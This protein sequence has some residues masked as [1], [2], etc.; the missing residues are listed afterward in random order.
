MLTVARKRLRHHLGAFLV[1]TVTAIVSLVVLGVLQLLGGIVTD[2]A[3]RTTVQAGDRAGR[4]IAVGGS[5]P[6][7][8][9]DAARA[10]IAEAAANQPGA[11]T[12]EVLEAVSRGISGRAGADRARL[13]VVADLPRWADVHEG[14][15]PEPGQPRL[16]VVIPAETA[17]AGGW[18]VGDEFD[19]LDLIREDGPALPA[20]ITGII[21]P[22]DRQDPI[23]FDQPLMRTGVETGGSFNLY[24][25]FLIAPADLAR[26]TGDSI[27]A[28]WRIDRPVRELTRAD[29][30]AYAEAA[31]QT[32][33]LL[34][35]NPDLPR[36]QVST[37]APSRYAAALDVADRTRIA[38]LT[39]TILLML[40]GA[41]ALSM[42]GLQLAGLREQ[43]TAL[44]RARGAGTRQVAGLAAVDAALVAALALGLAI[45]A[46]P[47][48]A[49]P[50][51]RAGGLTDTIAVSATATLRPGVLIP[52]AI[53]ALA[54]ALIVMVTAARS[55]RL[56]TA[57][58]QSRR[59]ALISRLAK[60]GIDLVLIG[61]GVLGVIQLRRYDA[62]APR[63]DPLTISAPALVICGLCVLGLRIIPLLARLAARAAARRTGLTLAWG[64][65]QVARRLSG[66]AGAILLVFLSVA[67]GSLALSQG[68]TISRAIEDQTR[69][70]VGG[71]L[72]VT[73][74]SELRGTT[75]LGPAYAQVAGDPRRSMAVHT[76]TVQVGSVKGIG[77]LAVDT[78]ASEALF[79]PRADILRGTAW[80]GGLTALAQPPV[81][82]PI[83]AG[84]RRIEADVAITAPE[85]G[86]RFFGVFPLTA[87]IYIAM[88]SGERLR[89]RAGT[90][91]Q[92]GRTTIGVDLAGDDGWPAGAR[93]VGIAAI[94]VASWL[95]AGDVAGAAMTLVGR[96]PLRVDDTPLEPPKARSS[97]VATTVYLPVEDAGMA[98]GPV[99]VLLT[100]AV[101][102]ASRLQVGSDVS[103][104]FVGST[105]PARVSGII[106]A[107]PTLADATHGIVADLAALSAGLV[108]SGGDGSLTPPSPSFWV[109]APT[110][111]AAARATLESRPR[112]AI[113]VHD[114]A[115]LADA[116][117]ANPVNAGMRAALRLVTVSA[118]LLATLGFAAATAALALARH[119]EG[120]ILLALG[121]PPRQ[122][123]RAVIGERLVV[124]T[125]SAIV[126]L[127]AGVT[128]AWAIVALI[129]GSDGYRQMPPV[130][131]E[132][133]L[134]S[135]LAF[136]GIVVVLLAVVSIL[137]IGRTARDPA[138]VLRAGEHT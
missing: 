124:L 33:R 111:V 135:L 68:A 90:I 79:R 3:A 123:R 31:Q 112:L 67:M 2:A 20:Q 16:Q 46:V 121:T 21:E 45:A 7:E 85:D 101:A 116:R 38:L 93:I 71:P 132:Y 37:E 15:L 25:P 1:L 138:D 51:A 100:R 27:T 35:Q 34:E 94:P 26:I 82:I 47:V 32:V 49:G 81:G 28:R 125:L 114:A 129:I 14:G 13:A 5:I 72:Q 74:G 65:W 99:P 50:L 22:K 106:E 130:S 43:E 52:L 70:S 9:L 66:Q 120:G 118:L 113:E 115:Q 84:A 134:P 131:T 95:T 56:R 127:G 117:R 107:V 98:A 6:L 59:G 23:W 109:L 54:A 17:A 36:V 53:A 104:A 12:T 4:T 63:L 110:D 97:V 40:L 80:P 92:A 133:G 62:T 105:L 11:T 64:S 55:G 57:T 8:R 58:P 86:N 48:L 69:F 75:G 60:S 42:S 122:I 24:G 44:M 78:A 61:F 96:E 10:A 73:P 29:A 136:V 102:E 126:G 103:I 19:L 89:L 76:A 137:V 88:P 18:A 119:R 108:R 41:V 128:A 83:P 91:E 39:P 87:S 77:L 30:A